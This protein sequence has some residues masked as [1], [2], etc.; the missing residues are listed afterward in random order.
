MTTVDT[1]TPTVADE[2]ETWPKLTDRQLVNLMLRSHLRPTRFTSASDPELHRFLADHVCGGAFPATEKDP[3][4]FWTARRDG[5]HYRLGAGTE[6]IL[7]WST[8]A[9][10]DENQPDLFEGLDQ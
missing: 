10:L 8:L 6:K 2:N 3:G 7:R 5:I 9:K 1:S 4:V